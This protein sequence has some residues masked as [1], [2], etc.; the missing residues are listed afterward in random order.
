MPLLKTDYHTIEDIYTLP[1]GQRAELIDRQIYNMAPPNRIHQKIVSQLTKIIGQYIDNKNGSCEVYPAPFAVF[2]D[3][4]NNNYV[5][6]DVSV[7][8]D[9]GKLDDRGCNGAPDWIIEITSPDSSSNDYLR[10]PNLYTNAGVR[11]YWIVDPRRKKVTVYYLKTPDPEIDTYTF[12]DK[13]KVNIYDDL[14]IDFK[15]LDI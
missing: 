9:K 7:I 10:K 11:E 5:E 1:E 8:C 13:I 6:P 2:L 15:E 3:K 14:W 4:N 12:Q